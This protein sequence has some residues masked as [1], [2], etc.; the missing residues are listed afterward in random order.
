MLNEDVKAGERPKGACLDASYR[1]KKLHT[2]AK[3]ECQG[4]KRQRALTSSYS[5]ATYMITYIKRVYLMIDA[6]FFMYCD[7]I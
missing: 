6:F 4:F 3:R 1:K 5:R 2:Y 7:I